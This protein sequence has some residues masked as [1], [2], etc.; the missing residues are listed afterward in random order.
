MGVGD[1][2]GLRNCFGLRHCFVGSRMAHYFPTLR[3]AK[4]TLHLQGGNEPGMGEE[5]GWGEA[6]GNEKI[7]QL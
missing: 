4:R 5:E 7:T 2:S 1:C 6:L 3:D